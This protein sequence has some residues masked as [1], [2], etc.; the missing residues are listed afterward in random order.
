M[1]FADA[2]I[3]RAMNVHSTT[4][5]LMQV[6]RTFVLF[7]LVILAFASTAFCQKEFGVIQGVVNDQE[8]NPIPGVTVTASS[9]SMIGGSMVSYTDSGGHFRFPA[10][11][12]GIYETRVELDGFKTVVRKDIQLFVGTV[13]TIDFVLEPMNVSEQVIVLGETPRLDATT[14]STPNTVGPEIIQNL[15]KPS[16]LFGNILALLAL[17]PGVGEDQVAYGAPAEAGNRIWVDGVDV[18]SPQFG[19]LYAEYAYNWIE[20]TQVVGIGAPA[21]YGGFTGVVGNYVTRSGGNQFHGLVEA[22]FQNENFVSTNVPDSGPKQPF[23]SYDFG[24]QLG[25]P[26][27]KDKLWFFTGLQYPYLQNHPFGYDGVTTEEYS[28]F[29]TKLTYKPNENNIIQGFAHYNNYKLDGDGASALVPVVATSV[30]TCN[31]SSW[32]ATWVSLLSSQTNLEMRFG[33]LWADCK[34]NPR[35]GDIPGHTDVITGESSVN[36]LTTERNR[37]FRPQ[38][39][40][41]ISHFA[42]DFMG[43]H[44]FKFGAQYERSSTENEARYNGGFSYYDY[45]GY[46]YLRYSLL[47]N[48]DSKNKIHRSSIFAQD[49]WNLSDRITLNLGMRWDHN[50]GGTNRGNVFA[51]DPVAPRIGLVW[52]LNEK[53]ATIF[54]AHYGDYYDALTASQFSLLTDSPVGFRADCFQPG[55]GE[56]VPCFEQQFNTSSDKKIHH[57]FVRQFTFGVDKDLSDGLTLGVHYIHRRWENILHNIDNT[58]RYQPAP[59]VNPITGE[60][61]TVFERIDTFGD[62]KTVLT[63]PSG[64]FRRYNGLEIEAN[65]RFFTRL[66]MTG[67]FVYSRVKGNISNTF[68]DAVVF[69]DALSNPNK[70]VN[71]EGRLTND[72]SVAW[73]IAGIYSFPQGFNT[74]WFLRHQSGDTWTPTVLVRGL[75]QGPFRIFGLPRGSNRLPSQTILDLRVEKQ[76]QIYSG[77]IRLTADISNLFNSAYTTAV[78]DHFESHSFGDPTDVTAPRSVRIG[79]RYTF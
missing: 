4:E 31:E 6:C 21:E 63:N 60:T 25:G 8:Q 3:V 76:F 20:E 75:N 39:N 30:D 14:A 69:S 67:S 24:A 34:K 23:K 17:T 26:I 73:K 53:S 50:R 54:K 42:Q 22:F 35:N 36:A 66:S 62:V 38:V 44:D 51:T 47:A 78:N 72:P 77:Q 7:L 5:E 11:A 56:W 13:L 52:R 2:N 74:G 45:Y 43:T 57:P 16:G 68:N 70:L 37:R 41:S 65:A 33:G 12:P 10:L 27:L 19:V 46:S 18:T 48:Q 58:T 15:P 61:I 29:I 55:S 32:N 9:N 59:F 49:D 71:F 28:K 1:W 64:L 40:A 79:L